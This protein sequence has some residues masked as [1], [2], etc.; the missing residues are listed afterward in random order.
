[1]HRKVVGFE[2][3]ELIPVTFGAL[4]GREMIVLYLLDVI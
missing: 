4:M 3:R 1:V 2:N